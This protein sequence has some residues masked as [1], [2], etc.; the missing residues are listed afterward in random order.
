MTGDPSIPRLLS[1]N[2]VLSRVIDKDGL[3]DKRIHHARI[4]AAAR[5]LAKSPQTLPFRR[6]VATSAALSATLT[7]C[8]SRGWKVAERRRV[9]AYSFTPVSKR[10]DR[11]DTRYGESAAP[12]HS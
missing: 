8:R 12:A 6:F 5:S 4:T 2:E 9:Q 10:P 7:D 3:K 11:P 1:G